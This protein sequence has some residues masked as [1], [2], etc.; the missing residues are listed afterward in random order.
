MARY[1]KEAK[2][3][4]NKYKKLQNITTLSVFVAAL[5]GLAIGEHATQNTHTEFVENGQGI[6]KNESLL[7][8]KDSSNA[9]N[10]NI[11]HKLI[12]SNWMNK[13]IN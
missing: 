9:L 2:Y 6:I 10:E 11:T 13:K 8:K 12:Q 5:S 4:Q 7:F 3:W 1:Y